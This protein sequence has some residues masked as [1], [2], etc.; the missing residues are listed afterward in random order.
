[1]LFIYI[2]IAP[3]I[4][5]LGQNVKL[6]KMLCNGILF[7][8]PAHSMQKKKKTKVCGFENFKKIFNCWKNKLC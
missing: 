6:Y 7:I 2:I 1:M 8:Y 4:M 5:N 3:N